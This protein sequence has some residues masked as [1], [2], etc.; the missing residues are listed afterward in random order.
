MVEDIETNISTDDIA[1]D[2]IEMFN[3]Y[4]GG[5]RVDYITNAESDLEFVNNVQWSRESVAALDA[6]NIPPVC[7]NEMKPARDQAVQQVTFNDPQFLAVG[8]EN[9]DATLAADINDLMD[10]IWDKSRGKSHFIKAVENFEDMGM[11]VLQT[12][13]DPNADG[14]K[15]DIKIRHIDARDIYLDPRCSWRSAQNSDRIFY[16]VVMSEDQIKMQY[17]DWDSREAQTW[18]GD[19]R[20]SGRGNKTEGQIFH[21]DFIA[22]GKTKYYRLIDEYRRIKHQMFRVSN[23]NTQEEWEF[24][25]GEYIAFANEYS[26]VVSSPMKQTVI[27]DKQEL[28][29]WSMRIQQY[30]TT[31]FHLRSDGT[32]QPGTEMKGSE[33]NAQGQL[34]MPVPGSTVQVDRTVNAQLLEEGLLEWAPVLVDRIQQT[35]VIGEKLYQKSVVT[36]FTTYPFGITMLHHTDTPY[37]YGDSRLARP[38]QEQINKTRSLIT[39]YNMNIASLKLFVPEGTDKTTLEKQWGKAGAQFFTYDPDLGGVP[40]VLQFQQMSTALYEQLDRDKYLIQRLYGVYEFQDGASVQFPQTLGGT[41]LIDEFAQRRSQFKR[42]LIEEAL[43]D[44]GMAIGDLIPKVYTERKI[45]R[46]V[47]PNARPRESVFNQR[48]ETGVYNDLTANEY[49]IMMVSGSTLPTHRGARLQ[50]A[51]DLWD[52]G[53]IK[54]S[55]AVIR[56]TDMPNMEEL[57]QRNSVI[58]QA[59][60]AIA[61]SQEI[62]KELQGDMQTADRELRYADRQIAKVKFEKKLMQ[63]ESTLKTAVETSKTLI[64]EDRKMQ[65]QLNNKNQLRREVNPQG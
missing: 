33:I 54:D 53:I 28:Q 43:D 40:I 50:T 41:V 49:D 20:Q 56:L 38:V 62:I 5:N 12:Y 11:F 27:T 44:L 52:R 46:I 25:Q 16:A 58:S 10:Y 59:E 17:P 9:S 51:M 24:E 61:Q 15:G 19:I 3:L 36:P 18:T 1:R 13:Y 4:A 45:I 39:A 57:I 6:K 42:G 37:P 30:R 64:K 32:W 47:K 22:S 8:R 21:S 65:K 55:E 7:Y 23:S 2:I 29:E 48:Q 26:L 31:R 60:Q 34:T 63:L 14:G 35:L